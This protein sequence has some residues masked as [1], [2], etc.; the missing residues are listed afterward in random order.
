M[1]LKNHP[2]IRFQFSLKLA[3]FDE[4]MHAF[5]QQQPPSPPPHIISYQYR[6]LLCF[7]TLKYF[8]HMVTVSKY[9]L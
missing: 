6:L 9:N 5:Q 7:I 1:L 2:L 8:H 3:Y 4:C